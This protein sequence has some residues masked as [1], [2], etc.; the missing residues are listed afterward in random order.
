MAPLNDTAS[1]RRTFGWPLSL[2]GNLG[3]IPKSI[4]SQPQNNVVFLDLWYRIETKDSRWFVMPVVLC[5]AGRRGRVPS[6]TCLRLGQCHFW[7]CLP[8]WPH[9][10]SCFYSGIAWFQIFHPFLE[11]QY[12]PY[13]ICFDKVTKNTWEW[14]ENWAHRDYWELL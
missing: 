10:S 8:G 6:S 3:D 7:R 14:P 13:I 11:Q 2:L 4:I 5:G 9:Y 1:M 12:T